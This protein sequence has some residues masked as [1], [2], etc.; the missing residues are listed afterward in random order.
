[1]REDGQHGVGSGRAA[2]DVVA[3]PLLCLDDVQEAEVD[4][5]LVFRRPARRLRNGLKLSTP[6]SVWA[7]ASDGWQEGS[8][9]V[10]GMADAEQ[11]VLKLL[12]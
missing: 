3:D 9:G 4:G 5:V 1:M 7:S 12:A 11:W 2:G 6:G 10:E 8:D